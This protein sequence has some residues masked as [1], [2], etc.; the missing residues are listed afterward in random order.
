MTPQ[1]TQLLNLIKAGDIQAPDALVG[2]AR[3]RLLGI[4]SYMLRRF[5]GVR[6]FEETDDVI[7]NAL[8]RLARA[9]SAGGVP[10]TAAHYWNLARV[11]IRRE[12]IDLSRHYCGKWRAGTIHPEGGAGRTAHDAGNLLHEVPDSSEEPRTLEAW[13][14]FHEAIGRLP[15]EEQQVFGL[16]WYM[17]LTQNEAAEELG[18]SLSTLGRRWRMARLLLDQELK[19]VS[20]L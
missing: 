19:G 8:I 10:D 6:R 11:Q 14:H 16:I 17:G 5:P 20:L 18:V 13:T 4:T 7:Q 12:L 1:T 15:E 2:H 9:L 3:R